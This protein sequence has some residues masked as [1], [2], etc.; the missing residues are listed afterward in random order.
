MRS[1]AWLRILL[2]PS[3]DDSPF[4]SDEFQAN[5]RAFFQTLDAAD[6]QVSS[7]ALNMDIVDARRPLMGEFVFSL[8][9]VGPAL[10]AA[11]GAWLEANAGRKL[12]LKIIGVEFEANTMTQLVQVLDKAIALREQRVKPAGCDK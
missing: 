12:R 11:L 6:I 3:A 5:L 7:V 1:P 8:A 4:F 9:Q 2:I 10:S